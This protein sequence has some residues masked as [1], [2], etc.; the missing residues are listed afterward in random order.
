MKNCILIKPP[1]KKITG[2]INIPG[3]KS[4]TNRALLIA[5]LAK[6]KS[7]LL[8]PLESDD[9]RYMKEALKKLGIKITE[10]KNSWLVH[11][12]AGR[13]SK[14]KQKLYL[15]SAG[16]A[17]RFLTASLTLAGFQTTLTGDKRM[18]QRPINPL[19]KSLNQLGANTKCIKQNN[20]PPLYI[21]EKKLAGGSTRIRGNLSSQYIS[22][23]LIACPY[24]EKDTDIEIAGELVSKPYID[25]TLKIMQKFG[26][27][28]KNN[29]YR[30][31]HIRGRQIYQAVSYQI[32]GDA[33]SASYFFALAALHGSSI[34]V[35]NIPLS[36]PQADIKILDFLKEIGCSIST[37]K[38]SITVTGPAKLK[39]VQKK[40]INLS[41]MP[42]AA[43]TIAVL[44]AFN[45][46]T[47]TLSGLHNL[48]IKESDRLKALV[49]EL[50]KIGCK[51]VETKDGLIIHGN[52]A[53]LKSAEI[54]TYNDH[55]IAMCF[56]IAATKIKNGLKIK[57]PGCVKKTYPNFWQDL[58]KVL[59]QK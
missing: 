46:G 13:F 27:K 26:V 10:N 16:T 53:K 57:N 35:K 44:C 18:Q 5:A 41:D 50:N 6:G 14:T 4:I 30:S 58:E 8:N 20:C 34:T 40:S 21:F 43:M 3:S 39:K 7:T 37:T 36:T 42:D 29:R 33:S 59:N 23:L 17:I 9:T 52:P 32:D 2:K 28:A 22:A 45:H 38:K 11:G 25:T 19:L 51:T 15:G 12:R 24:A 56:A 55:R 49:N 54:E 48:R 1:T 31:F 47:V